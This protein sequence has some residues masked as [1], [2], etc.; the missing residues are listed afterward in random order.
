MS[1]PSKGKA[2]DPTIEILNMYDFDDCDKMLVKRYF[3]TSC[4]EYYLDNTSHI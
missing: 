4:S 1:K 3:S 2:N